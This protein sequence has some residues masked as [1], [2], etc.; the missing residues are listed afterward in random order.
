M[1]KGRKW[2]RQKT[3]ESFEKIEEDFFEIDRKQ[4]SAGIRLTFDKVSDI[5]D[6]N[7][8][9]KMPVLSDDFMEWIAS[10]FN[11][12]PS[13][14]K[15]E[16]S[17]SFKDYEGYTEK[18][19][20]EIFWKNI[21]LDARSK[22]ENQKKRNSIAYGLIAVGI[23]FFIG[24]ILTELRWD[25]ESVMKTIVSYISD[26][27]TTVAFWEAMTILIVERKEQRSY[28]KAVRK[29]FIG[30]SFGRKGGGREDDR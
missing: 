30:V 18:Q 27:A 7:Y 5:F 14:Y 12:I 8:M 15:I 25:T 2:M 3:F 29:R 1:K 22:W 13:R 10:A 28:L 20:N 9:T 21:L 23:V 4:Q 11:I 24:M 19:L 16:L 6:I 26:I 17:V